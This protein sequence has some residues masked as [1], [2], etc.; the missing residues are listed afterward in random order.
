MANE[1]HKPF[2]VHEHMRRLRDD[3]PSNLADHVARRMEGSPLLEPIVVPVYRTGRLPFGLS[4]RPLWPGE[5]VAL[6]DIQP[7]LPFRPSHLVVTPEVARG[8]ELVDFRIG[9]VG[10]ILG[11][12]APLPLDTFSIEYKKNDSLDSLQ[13]WQGNTCDVAQKIKIAVRRTP[14]GAAVAFRGLLWGYV[15]F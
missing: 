4:C 3:L 10:Q 14:D 1:G 5:R 9:N 13:G 11:G 15:A 12:G 6:T 7:E 8:F 2:D